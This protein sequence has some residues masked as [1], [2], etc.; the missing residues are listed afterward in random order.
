MG[1]KINYCYYSYHFTNKKLGLILDEFVPYKQSIEL[2]ELGYDIPCF[3]SYSDENTFN[4]TTG[5]LMYRVTP[6]EDSFCLAPLYQQAFL[7]LGRT[8]NMELN[9]PDVPTENYCNWL[10]VLNKLIQN[11]KETQK[12]KL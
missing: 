5:G 3:G 1:N 8:Q 4:F 2:K 10:E 12:I 11:A 6:S 7:W 9:I